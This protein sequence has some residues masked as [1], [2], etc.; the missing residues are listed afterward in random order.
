MQEGALA[1]HRGPSVAERR[2]RR[3]TPRIRIARRPVGIAQVDASQRDAGAVF[4]AARR[5]VN[6]KF[7]AAAK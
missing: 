5:A 2:L 3:S 1:R 4:D 7:A 6:A